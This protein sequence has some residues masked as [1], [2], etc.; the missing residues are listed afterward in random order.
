LNVDIYSGELD[1][2]RQMGF[3]SAVDKDNKAAVEMALEAYLLSSFQTYPDDV[4]WLTRWR[5][6][7]Q[8][9]NPSVSLTRPH[10]VVRLEC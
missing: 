7:G 2:L 5:L 3:L 1:L 4:P 8:R 10:R 9:R 6:L